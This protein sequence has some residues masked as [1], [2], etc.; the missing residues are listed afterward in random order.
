MNAIIMGYLLGFLAIFVF[1]V[2]CI[3]TLGLFIAHRA[4]AAL[5]LFAAGVLCAAVL[6]AVAILTL[7]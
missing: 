3:V 4:K 5:K 2:V 1:A 6:A 7:Y